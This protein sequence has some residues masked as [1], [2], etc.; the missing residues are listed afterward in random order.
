MKTYDTQTLKAHVVEKVLEERGHATASE[1]EGLPPIAMP[2][3]HRAI[4]LVEAVIR[5]V[6]R[7][8]QWM[9]IHNLEARHLECFADRVDGPTQA[10]RRVEVVLPEDRKAQER[11][12]T[13]ERRQERLK[14]EA[15]VRVVR[16]PTL[17]ERTIHACVVVE[18]VR[19][20]AARLRP[21]RH[22]VIDDRVH[23]R[24]MGARLQ[25]V[26]V[27]AHIETLLGCTQARPEVLRVMRHEGRQ[28][29]VELV[30]DREGLPDRPLGRPLHVH[31]E[32]DHARFRE[33][34]DQLARHSGP[35][36]T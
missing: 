16:E 18:A 35:S 14:E 28:R 5:A 32:R 30:S 25:E 23:R 34:A 1:P 15:E 8:H 6:E 4:A 21:E 27:D 29:D 10:V 36:Q 2:V 12:A 17:G 13:A 31:R 22:D 24:A 7:D 26:R 3:V 11:S 9:D 19:S 33:I 20:V